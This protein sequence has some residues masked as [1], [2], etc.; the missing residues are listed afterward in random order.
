MKL[1]IDLDQ[2]AAIQ[3]FAV[4]APAVIFDFK[5]QDTIY[6][7]IYFVRSG[8]VQDLGAG[9]AI[10]YGMIATGDVT[11]T[12]L[13]YQAAFT[14]LTDPVG[15]VYYNCQVV[16]NT[17]Q[18]ASA[19][20]GKTQLP[21]TAEIRYQTA[22]NEIIHSLNISC[23]VFPTILVETGVTPPGVSTGYPD[24][25]TLELLVHKNVASGYAGLNASGLL[26]GSII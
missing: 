22:D 14:Y 2:H 1:V 12:I 8:I 9:M 26:N 17:S 11:D 6:W 24:A 7:M 13:A 19:I 4:G 15:N 3:D 5:S 18:M 23:L 25:S 21:C 20:S 10:K 16:Y